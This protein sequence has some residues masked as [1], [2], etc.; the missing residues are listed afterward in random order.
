MSNIHQVVNEIVP[1]MYQDVG[2][3]YPLGYNL[4]SS[5]Q[6]HVLSKGLWLALRQR[7]IEARREYH[8]APN[9]DWHYFIAHTPL[10]AEPQED[11]IIT[12]LNPWQFKSG[13]APF[14]QFLHGPRQQVIAELEQAGASSH[15]RSLRALSTVALSHHEHINSPQVTN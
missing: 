14:N 10:D 15:V 5:N 2:Q 11:D 9:G 1:A 8:E 12:D 3:L 4:A 6:C 13:S 7:D